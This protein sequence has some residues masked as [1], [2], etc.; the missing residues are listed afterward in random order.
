LG[1]EEEDGGGGKMLSGGACAVS[2]HRGRGGGR[3]GGVDAQDGVG[4]ERAICAVRVPVAAPEVEGWCLVGWGASH[5]V[6]FGGE[7]GDGGSG[8]GVGMVGG[9]GV[10]GGGGGVVGWCLASWVPLRVSHL[11]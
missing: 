11:R 5:R 10:R 8:G 7:V 9:G 1:E 6:N 4:R 3:G 2:Y